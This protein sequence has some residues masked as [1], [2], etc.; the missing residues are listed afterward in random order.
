METE[1][2]IVYALSQAQ[3]TLKE[4]KFQWH[5]TEN[6][7]PE[8]GAKHEATWRLYESSSTPDAG[9]PST[10]K[11]RKGIVRQYSHKNPP[12]W[13]PDPFSLRCLTW[14]FTGI[15]IP[16]MSRPLMVERWELD[17][18]VVPSRRVLYERM[19]EI[20]KPEI[21]KEANCELNTKG[22]CECVLCK[23]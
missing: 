22:F 10:T 1:E 18:V 4:I 3:P 16:E 21:M 12:R 11:R 23:C 19:F 13:T 9:H 2:E 17:G 20:I 5:C 14:W 6:S 15:G 7:I 8:L